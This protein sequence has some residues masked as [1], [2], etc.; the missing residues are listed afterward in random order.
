MPRVPIDYNNTLIY[1]IVCKNLDVK[2]IYVGHTTN[3]TKRKNQHKINYNKEY[4]C[5]LY[6]TIQDNGGWNN[7]VMIEIKR[8]PC[9]DSNEAKARERFY[10]E[11]L[12][13]NLNN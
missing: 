10:I 5:K 2:D 13:A 7:W 4:N 1:K 9:N 8:F 6:R 12:N 11:H 3:F